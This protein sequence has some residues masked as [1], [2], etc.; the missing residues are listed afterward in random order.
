MSDLLKLHA[1]VQDAADKRY[2]DTITVGGEDYDIMY[3]QARDAETS[4][5]IGSVGKEK[6]DE[7]QEMFD[8]TQTDDETLQRLQKLS[9]KEQNGRLSDEEREEFNQ[10]QEEIDEQDGL[11]TIAADQD[12]VTALQN[13]ACRV[14][15]PDEDDIQT[16]LEM[17]P[18]KQNARFGEY[19]TDDDAAYDMAKSM[20]ED[21]VVKS[22]DFSSVILGMKGLYIGQSGGNDQN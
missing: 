11:F 1:D 14:V 16:I 2:S 10:L 21:I 5:F 13:I 6:F 3:R 20:V 18:E 7:W 22:T 12:A 8:G 17:S 15:E 9:Q 19:A 4:E